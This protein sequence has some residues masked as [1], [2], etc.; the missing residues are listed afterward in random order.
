M[1]KG[2][3]PII[4]VILLLLITIG[5]VGLSGGLFTGTVTDAGQNIN[6]SLNATVSGST[7]ILDVISVGKA[8]T[9][10]NITVTIRNAGG[11]NVNTN[12]IQFLIDGAIH[13]CLDDVVIEQSKLNICELTKDGTNAATACTGNITIV[14][15]N[16]QSIERPCP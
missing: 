13:E 12:E 6:T 7:K 9:T 14:L 15:L 16:G 8:G 3:T 5:V 11:V 1:K 4:A 10:E 2:I